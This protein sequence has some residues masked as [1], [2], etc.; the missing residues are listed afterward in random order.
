MKEDEGRFRLMRIHI[1]GKLVGD[2]SKRSMS[3]LGI[4]V[5]GRM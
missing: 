5:P 1:V 4:E 2:I 3:L